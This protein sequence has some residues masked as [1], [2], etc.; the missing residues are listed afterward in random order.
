MS[1]GPAGALFR[2]KKEH[3]PNFNFIQNMPSIFQKFSTGSETRPPPPPQ[4]R[5]FLTDSK[6]CCAQNVRK[7]SHARK[8]LTPTHSKVNFILSRAETTL[9]MAVH[10]RKSKRAYVEV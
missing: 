1:S 10:A 5:G 8:S 6:L 9:R 7:L 3:L 2:N 4:K